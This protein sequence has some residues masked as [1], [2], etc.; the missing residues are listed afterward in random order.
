MTPVLPDNL[1][2]LD[3]VQIEELRD[4][5]GGAGDLLARIV[6]VFVTHTEN[7]LAALGELL[8][9][10]NQDLAKIGAIAHDMCSGAGSVGARRLALAARLRAAC[11]RRLDCAAL[12]QPAAD[13]R[14]GQRNTRAL[15]S[16]RATACAHQP[17]R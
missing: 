3:A 17:L 8:Q 5:D 4:L 16:L 11:S 14:V 1:P 10:E 2:I 6:G 12:R 13:C 9:S 15:R 7:H